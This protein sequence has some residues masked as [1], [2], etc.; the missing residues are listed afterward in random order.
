MNKLQF[1]CVFVHLFPLKE[2]RM[3]PEAIG[4]NTIDNFHETCLLQNG[5]SKV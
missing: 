2:G 4:Y 5:F 1:L 3:T